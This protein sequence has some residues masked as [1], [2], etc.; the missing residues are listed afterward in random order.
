VRWREQQYSIRA[1]GGVVKIA[2]PGLHDVRREV[3]HIFWNF[4]IRDVVEIVFFL[5]SYG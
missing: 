2:L 4:F 1:K 5:A 3:E